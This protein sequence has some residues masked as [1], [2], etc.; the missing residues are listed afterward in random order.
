MTLEGLQAA[1]IRI[2]EIQQRVGALSA[3]AR[4]ASAPR[5]AGTSFDTM[6]STAVAETGAGGLTP[7][8]V[9]PAGAY[10]RLTP[11]AELAAYGNGRVP[12]GALA[13]IGHG[14][15]RL[16]A[17]AAGAFARMEA[18]AARAG[19][20]I[21]VTDSYRSYDE[22]VAVAQRKGLHKHGG[23]AATPGHSNHGWGM[24][25]DLKL[26]AAA[27]RWMRANGSR[28]G[29]VEDVTREPWHWT[30]RPAGT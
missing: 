19:V 6:F 7:A 3:P 18:D 23:L 1:Q 30:Y 22:Q 8:Q 14:D 11:P 2:A 13:S 10:G 28:Y 20:N 9:K 27:Q 25:L 15:H 26:D 5:T 17:P 21:G 29:F 4:G 16:W 12:A 24:S